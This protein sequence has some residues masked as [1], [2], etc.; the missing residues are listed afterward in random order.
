MNNKGTLPKL[1]GRLGYTNEFRIYNIMF[2]SL[3]IASFTIT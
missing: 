1:N 2:K 3:A